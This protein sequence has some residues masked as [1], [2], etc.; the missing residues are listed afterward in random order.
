MTDEN[1]RNNENRRNNEN[2]R[3]NEME[4]RSESASA[5][6]ARLDLDINK[7]EEL[8]AWLFGY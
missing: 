1:E 8:L 4:N 2:E 7:V 6:R 5:E 3:D